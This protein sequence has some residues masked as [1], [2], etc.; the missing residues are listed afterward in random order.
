MPP[1]YVFNYVALYDDATDEW[2]VY[3]KLQKRIPKNVECY[4]DGWIRKSKSLKIAIEKPKNPWEV[5]AKSLGSWI[6]QPSKF[7]IQVIQNV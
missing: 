2:K 6:R 1:K 3:E 5:G 4:G 7:E